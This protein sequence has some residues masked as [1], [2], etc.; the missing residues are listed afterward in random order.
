MKMLE[1]TKYVGMVTYQGR[2]YAL[3]ENGM[4]IEIFIDPNSNLSNVQIVLRLPQR[5]GC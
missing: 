3:T 4:L 2:L 5:Q 1:Y